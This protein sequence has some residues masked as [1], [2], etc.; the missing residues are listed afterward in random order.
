[1]KTNKLIFT[2]SIS[3]F[4]FLSIFYSYSYY[5]KNIKYP[6][7]GGNV[8]LRTIAGCDTQYFNAGTIVYEIA[9]INAI[10]IIG[11]FVFM[12][13][14]DKNQKK[15]WQIIKTILMGFLI[16]FLIFYGDEMYWTFHCNG[17]TGVSIYNVMAYFFNYLYDLLTFSIIIPLYWIYFIG[18]LLY[19]FLFL[20]VLNYKK[21]EK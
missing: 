18:Y 21:N 4:L 15:K 16:G 11:L 19:I 7:G 8:F 9:V 17:G 12:S 13:L 6:T 5:W 1:M 3:L 14:I 20:Y 10:I 2:I